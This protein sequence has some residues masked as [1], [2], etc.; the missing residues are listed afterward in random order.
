MKKLTILLAL[1]LLAATLP[2][3]A[4][5][6]TT[7]GRFTWFGNWDFAGPTSSGNISYGRIGWDVKVDDFNTVKVRLR[8]EDVKDDWFSTP[9]A[10]FRLKN[11]M[12]VSDLTG[13]LGLK[14]PVTVKAT[15][16]LFDTYF[17]GWWYASM[18]GWEGYYALPGVAGAAWDGMLVQVDRVKQGAV[19]LDVGVLEKATLHFYTDLWGQYVMVGADSSAIPYTSLW[20]AYGASGDD[21][22]K[23]DMSVE[24]KV[25][26]PEFVEGLKLMVPAFFRYG[27]GS[28]D[29]S[30]MGGL[31]ADYKMFHV[32]A[33]IQ[34]D[35]EDAIHHIV[36][37]LSVVPIEAAKIWVSLYMDQAAP[38]NPLSAVDIA[39]SYKFGAM[40]LVVGYLIGGEDK[41]AIP[42]YGDNAAYA[43]GLYFGF[44]V[45][46]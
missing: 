43:N 42:L 20:L 2:V 12:L 4:L 22:A 14:L 23:G 45:S 8:A 28:K 19:Q 7:T 29:L 15:V 18:S 40:N 38:L 44:D 33:G 10:D 24:A 39:A 26:L 35:N 37:D 17:T 11:F 13:A 9:E 1:V 27:L 31:A 6:V 21:F 36:A 3:F 46:F 16:G 30:W 32:G 34:G 5:E 41:L 25:D